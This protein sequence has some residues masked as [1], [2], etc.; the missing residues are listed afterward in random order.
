MSCIH[1]TKFL[2]RKVTPNI[3]I[4][5][6]SISRVCHNLENEYISP[7]FFFFFVVFIYIIRTKALL[8]QLLHPNKWRILFYRIKTYKRIPNRFDM[9]WISC[10]THI[11]INFNFERVERR[12][13]NDNRL[14]WRKGINILHI[15][16]ILYHTICS[17]C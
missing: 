5:Y 3:Y 2:K 12:I 14:Y 17:S 10:T 8:F 4:S 15:M 1:R 6:I 11:R 9:N 16:M 13:V 7:N